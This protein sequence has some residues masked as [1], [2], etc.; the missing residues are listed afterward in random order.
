MIDGL[1]HKCLEDEEQIECPDD[2]HRSPQI[3]LVVI[4]SPHLH[5]DPFLSLPPHVTIQ[6]R[7]MG[8]SVVRRVTHLVHTRPVTPARP[9]GGVHFHRLNIQ[10]NN[11]SV[12]CYPRQ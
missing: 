7:V 1:V 11:S 5:F 10:N 8:V 4:V 2:S 6:L 9:V 12:Q 3:C